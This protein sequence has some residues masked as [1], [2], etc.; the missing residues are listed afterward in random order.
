MYKMAAEQGHDQAQQT[1][2]YCYH[3]GY[4]ISPDSE[5]ANY[6]YAKA[7]EQGNDA[8]Q[9]NLGINYYNGDGVPQ[10]YSSAVTG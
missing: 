9:F 1:V 5:S 3:N 4:G 10:D 6:W 2:G 7:A 8:A